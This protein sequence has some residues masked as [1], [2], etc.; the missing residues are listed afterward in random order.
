MAAR[1]PR[2]LGSP[3]PAKRPCPAAP[4]A[5]GPAHHAQ[6]AVCL[7]VQRLR[8]G[9]NVNTLGD[10]HRPSVEVSNDHIQL[11]TKGSKRS[12]A[13]RPAAGTGAARQTHTLTSSWV[14]AWKAAL[15]PMMKGVGV[16]RTSSSC[17]GRMGT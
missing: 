5:P 2:A 13:R 7:T 3:P 1:R 11:W 6:N 14:S 8:Q 4:A 9:G 12:G 16:L 10:S 17:A 15:T